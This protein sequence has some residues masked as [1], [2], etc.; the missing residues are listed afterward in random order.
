MTRNRKTA[1]PGPHAAR[2]A[3]TAAR[4]RGTAASRIVMPAVVV[5]AG[6]AAYIDSDHGSFLFD[7]V[8][9][10]VENPAIRS[11]EAAFRGVA[12]AER[13]LVT[14]SLA[15]NYS[16]SGLGTPSYHIFNLAVHLLAALTLYALI[17]ATLQTPRFRGTS[18]QRARWP[19]FVTSLLWTVHPLQTESVTYLIQRGESLMGLF[20]L[21]TLYATVR[22]AR[23]RRPGLWYIGAVA[24]CALGMAS[25]AVM[26][27][28]PL[29]VLLYDR[30]FLSGSV[31][32]TWRRRWPLYLGLAA[33]WL[34]LMTGGQAGALLDPSR[35]GGITVGL[36]YSGSTPLE[37]ALTQPGVILH[38]LRLSLWPRPLCLDYWWPLAK[39]AGSI[40]PQLVTVT[41]LLAATV[42]GFWRWPA[43]GF[44]GAWFFLV[45]APTSSFVPVQDPAFEHRMYLPLVAVIMAIVVG[46]HW[47]LERLVASP[48]VRRAVATVAVAGAALIF[49]A[50]TWR[51][52]R[53]YESPF[54][55]WAD[56]VRTRP[57]NPRAH[58][59]YG[60][61][62]AERGRMDEAIEHFETA[63]RL[64]P[65]YFQAHN[66]LGNALAAK[67]RFA[68]AIA[69]YREAIRLWDGYADAHNNLGAASLQS[70]KLEEAIVE[71]RRA[72]ELDP[73]NLIAA[74]NL[75]LA[76]RDQGRGDETIAQG[77]AWL[78]LQPQNREAAEIVGV[79]LA[80][81]GDL[82][83]AVRRYGNPALF[84]PAYVEAYVRA[85]D[86][87]RA[88]GNLAEAAADY[89]KA[90]AIDPASDAARS[91]LAA[92]DGTPA[93]P[94]R[95]SR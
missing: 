88:L 70:G 69:H 42:A 24:A 11:F 62:L 90:L 67:G 80:R 86:E 63:I 61:A 9:S 46:V 3:G 47:A 31:A 59:D 8:R 13:P 19:A 18:W 87:H 40:V 28:A 51:R 76:L 72:L 56:V 21:L 2:G 20:Y 17:G 93:T 33:T 82:D 6:V 66:N 1:N 64:M 29:V 14:L 50:A 48:S 49:V 84:G 89:R 78:R 71:F 73:G 25:K 79:A 39:T 43:V 41:A 91:R 57:S 35:R 54:V 94:G 58:T 60:K 37:Y 12:G 52:N 4:A 34:V 22:G 15:L 92:L 44:L 16:I 74:R 55:M 36:G 77:M 83:D 32:E 95:S 85:G 81:H 23:S 30:V 27:T 10:I 65:G 5:L 26:V 68:D 7:D 53:D 38:Y 75:T 45:L